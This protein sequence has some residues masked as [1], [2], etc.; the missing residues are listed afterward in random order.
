MTVGCVNATRDTLRNVGGYFWLLS[1][2]EMGQNKIIGRKPGIM[3][4]SK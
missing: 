3:D 4:I 1:H 2:D